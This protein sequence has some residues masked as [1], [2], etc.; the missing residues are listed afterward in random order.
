MNAHAPVCVC[1]SFSRKKE[2]ALIVALFVEFEYFIPTASIII[3]L[4]SNIWFSIL[5]PNSNS[6]K[7][8]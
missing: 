7:L 3:H 4:I 8:A 6:S 5:G 1:D 2:F